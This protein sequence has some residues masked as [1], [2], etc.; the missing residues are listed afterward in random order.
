MNIGI[1]TTWF[2]AG[3]GYVSKAYRR[4]L[5]KEHTVFIYARAGR[6][7]KNDATWDD[8]K[9]TWAPWHYATTGIWTGHF[10]RWICNNKIDIIIFNEQRH[11]VPILKAKKTGVCV[12]AYVDYYTQE[13][14]TAFAI[15]DFLIC[16]TR[17]HFSVFKWHP[18]CYYVPWGTDTI[19]YSPR[20]DKY[21]RPLRFLVSSGWEGSGNGDR[22]GTLLALKSFARLVG[23]CQLILYSQIPLERCTIEF[24]SLVR[25]DNR[26]DFRFGTFDPFPFEEGDV[27]LY[28]SRLDGIGL[29][30][31]EAISCG[32]AAITTDCA[33]MNEFVEDD[34]NGYLVKVSR[35]LGRHDGYY[36]AESICDLDSLTEKMQNYINEPPVLNLHKMNSR[37]FAEKHLDWYLNSKQLFKIIQNFKLTIQSPTGDLIQQIKLL[38]QKNNPGICRRWIRLIFFTIKELVRFTK[39]YILKN[40]N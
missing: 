16:N 29:S 20:K 26:V 18:N 25:A 33:P 30:L 22:R 36:W 34:F 15:Y 13:T 37:L 17:R 12:G 11:W 3:A 9:V 4:T 31:P 6:R 23:D 24:Q 38:D 28:P 27:Y 1:V 32:L 7:M 39:F 35:Y 8:K 5:E 21:N 2:P 40:N 14:V 10:K 19:L